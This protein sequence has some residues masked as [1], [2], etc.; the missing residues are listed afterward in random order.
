MK[1]E[2]EPNDCEAC[3]RLKAGQMC[4]VCRRLARRKRRVQPKDLSVYVPDY[5]GI[6]DYDA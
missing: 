2:Q 3:Q 6:H 5:N 4:H 1:N